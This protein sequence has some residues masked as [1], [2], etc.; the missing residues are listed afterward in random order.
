MPKQF[1]GSRFM[2]AP[3]PAGFGVEFQKL[4]DN[5]IQA[6]VVFGLEKEGPPG[7]VHGGALAAVLDEAMGSACFAIGRPG[8][9]ATITVD[10]K[11]PV[12]LGAEVL[13]RGQVTKTEGRKTYT[14]AK[15]V[16]PDGSIAAESTGIFVFSQE[17]YDKIRALLAGEEPRTDDAP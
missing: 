14:Y 7:H 5:S 4:D 3:P 17:L 13:L 2:T 8:L 12:P 9:S 1:T 16:L 6:R 15:I 11:A 10:Y